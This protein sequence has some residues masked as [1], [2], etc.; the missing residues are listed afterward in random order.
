[1]SAERISGQHSITESE[2]TAGSSTAGAAGAREAVAL[3]F[4]R[5]MG[6]DFAVPLC[7]YKDVDSTVTPVIKVR[8][9][10]E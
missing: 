6:F 2:P 10:V 7:S 5:A 3:V 4:I 1:M 9:D 8:S